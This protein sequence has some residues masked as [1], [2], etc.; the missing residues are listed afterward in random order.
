MYQEEMRLVNFRFP[1]SLI[2]ELE[3]VRSA[4]GLPSIAETVR[5]AIRSYVEANR[6]MIEG[7]RR[8][9]EKHGTT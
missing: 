2:D 8:L 3:D 4:M 9:R 1:R 5:A 6:P 7:V